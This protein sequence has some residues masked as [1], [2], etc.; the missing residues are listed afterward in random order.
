MKAPYL[1]AIVV[2]ALASSPA[3]RA[4]DDLLGVPAAA[5]PAANER[6][7]YY[8]TP[9]ATTP[10]EVAPTLAQQKSIQRASQ[11]MARLDSMRW[12]GLS[13][14]RPTASA[15]VF[16]TMYSPAFQSPGG[17]PFAWN[18]GGRGVTIFARPT[19]IYR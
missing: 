5:P 16:T 19:A 12:Y 9:A 11:R 7:W 3:A 13:G 15:L 18:A 6:D 2:A 17:R 1:C 14:S 8:R 10:K 4:A